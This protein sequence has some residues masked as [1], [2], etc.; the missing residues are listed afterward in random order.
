MKFLNEIWVLIPARSGSTGLKNKNIKKINGKP[1]IYY[2]L[3]TAHKVKKF[4][5]IIFSSDSD[6][7]INIAKK[8]FKNILIHK[9]GIKTSSKKASELSVF[10]DFIKK[11]KNIL[12]K[13]FAHLRPTCPIRKIS[14]I[15]NSID[16]FMKIKKKYSSLKT[17]TEMSDP[18][19]RNF[20]IVDGKICSILRK[21]FD[22]QKYWKPRQSFEKTYF[23]NCIIDIYKTEN[24]LKG[25][26]FGN[27]IFPHIVKDLSTDIDSMEDFK[28]S[29][30]LLAKN[31]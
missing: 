15:N 22:M 23:G 20:R 3:E 16:K 17:V 25:Y 10:Q 31:F 27:K 19:Y 4:K 8:Y 13:Y 30:Y 6:R 24:I 5:K 12:P 28:Y 11:Q 18:A 14:T 9:R 2:S 21:D 7:Y 1:L 26:L 29:K